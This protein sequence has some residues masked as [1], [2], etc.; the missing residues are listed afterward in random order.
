MLL[1]HT[2]HLL[3][4][5]MVKVD[6]ATGTHRTLTTLMVK[7]VDATGTHRTLTHHTDGE[8]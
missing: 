4:T 7:A 8:G 5:L 2:E 6:D 3:T 1:E